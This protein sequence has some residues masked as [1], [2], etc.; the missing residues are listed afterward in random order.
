MVE[1]SRKLSGRDA[2]VD[3]STSYVGLVVFEKFPKNLKT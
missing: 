2:S 3:T 1:V